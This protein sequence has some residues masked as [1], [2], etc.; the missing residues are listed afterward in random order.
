MRTTAGSIIKQRRLDMKCPLGVMAKK[1]RCS[2]S[3]LSD[4]EHSK[5]FP[6]PKMIK[7]LA[8]ALKADQ[9]YLSLIFGRVPDRLRQK[10]IVQ[11]FTILGDL[12]VEFETGNTL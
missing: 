8:K 12:Q 9:D 1:M 2:D 7:R 4:I 3:H 5:R 11:E 10:L 6:T